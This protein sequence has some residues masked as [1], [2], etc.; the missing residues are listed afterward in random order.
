MKFIH[1]DIVI[2]ILR[3]PF[4]QFCSIKGMN[5]DKQVL[6]VCR[7]IAVHIQL[8]KVEIVQNLLECPHALLQDLFSVRSKKESCLG[9]RFFEPFVVKSSDHSFSDARKCQG[10]DEYFLNAETWG[11]IQKDRPLF[12]KLRIASRSQYSVFYLFRF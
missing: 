6:Y 3:R 11:R 7:L 1:A 10:A 5:A 8:A 9:I 12:S 4:G 2:K